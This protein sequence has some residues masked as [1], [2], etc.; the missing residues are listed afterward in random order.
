M[1]IHQAIQKAKL[2]LKGKNIKT[3]DLDIQILMTKVLKKDRKFII[4]NPKKEISNESLKYFN[5][6]VTKRSKG[7]PV[8]YLVKKKIFLEV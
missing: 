3:L 8:A 5:N 4:L 2:L 1:N 7:E 6:L